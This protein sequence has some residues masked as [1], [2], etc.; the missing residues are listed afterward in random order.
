MITS[1]IAFNLRIEI[2]VRH[3]HTILKVTQ[4]DLKH[5]SSYRKLHS[6]CYIFC[7]LTPSMVLGKVFK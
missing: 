3:F 4:A 1:R 7:D 2:L 6:K 5:Q